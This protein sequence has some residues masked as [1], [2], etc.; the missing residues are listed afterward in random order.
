MRKDRPFYAIAF[1]VALC[2]LCAWLLTMAQ[3]RWRPRIEANENYARVQ[4][5]VEALGLV[6]PG[7]SREAVT[8]AFRSGITET[9]RGEMTIWEGHKNGKSTGWAVLLEG[10]GKYGPI[11]GI[12]AFAPDERHIKALRIYEQQETPGLGGRIASPEWLR[13]FQGLPMV[14]NGTPGIVI[15]SKIKG[16][17]VVDAITGAS[18]TTYSLGKLMNTLINRFLSG[19]MALEPLDL[20]LGPDAVT[21]ATPGYP[22][23]LKKPPN[24]RREV[25]RPDFMVPPGT[26]NLARGKKVTSSMTEEPIIGE[27]PQIVDGVKKSGEFDY[28][29]LDPGLQWV[30]I[31]LGAE[32]TVYGIV[33]WHYYKNP[34]IYN[35]VIVAVADDAA[36]TR[37]RRIVF[38]ND[39]DNS[40]GLGKGTDTSYFARWWGE[41]VDTRGPSKNGIRTRYVRVYTNGG[42]GGEDTRFVE[43]A[44]YGK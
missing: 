24:L 27:L 41:L 18:K 39:Y 5:L 26:V 17:N 31:D 44:V 10:R 7:A 12:L 42:C 25:R 23:N 43:I 15:S 6:G 35:D 21:R 20:Q 28:V 22:K 19:G 1:T 34:V 4:A 33:I 2:C 40:A 3:V 8:K 37:N 11:K 38:N 16:P 32:H 36:F 14:T 29:E 9:K 13:Q 30:Q